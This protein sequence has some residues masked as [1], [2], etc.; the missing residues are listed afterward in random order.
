MI[1]LII[2][3][4]NR[5]K[6]LWL[7]LISLIQQTKMPDEII[8]ADDGSKIETKLLIDRFIKKYNVFVNHVWQ[9][10]QGFRLSAIRNKAIAVARG[11]YIIQIDGDL[12]LHKYFIEDH[13]NWARKNTFISGTRCLLSKRLT[14]HLIK[15]ESV[16]LPFKIYPHYKKI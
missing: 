9:E 10:D 14:N 1:S 16:I 4:Y 12:I 2:T 15:K 6:A 11:D 8:I 7:T 5:P 3:T 13:I